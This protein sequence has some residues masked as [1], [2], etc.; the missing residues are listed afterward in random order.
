MRAISLSDAQGRLHDEAM[1]QLVVHGFF[2]DSE[3]DREMAMTMIRHERSRLSRVGP[4]AYKMSKLTCDALRKA[5]NKNATMTLCGLT[6]IVMAGRGFMGQSMALKPSAEIVSEL[7]YA[8][9]RVKWVSYVTGQP[10][11]KSMKATGDASNIEKA[12]R[13]YRSVAH[14]CAAR[15]ATAEYLAPLP[16]LERAPEAEACL[17]ATAA[18]HQAALSRAPNFARWD[19]WDVLS[20]LPQEIL[21]YPPLVPSEEVLC[22]IWRPWDERQS[23]GLPAGG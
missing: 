3:E 19:V 6:A 12:F 16:L 11:E 4:D 8:T 18:W 15:V 20:T 7:I 10:K 23:A 14:I 9:G 5:E 17:L 13:K 1:F 2:P 22:N 21:S